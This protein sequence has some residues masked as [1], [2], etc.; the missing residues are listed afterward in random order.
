MTRFGEQEQE[1]LGYLHQWTNGAFWNRLVIL[2]RA[3]FN[4]ESL[5]E[6]SGKDKSYWFKSQ[7][8]DVDAIRNLILNVGKQTNKNGQQKWTIRRN[9]RDTPLKSTDLQG[10]K[11]VPFD[12]K[13]TIFC[14]K[15]RPGCTPADSQKCQNTKFRK[16]CHKMPIWENEAPFEDRQFDYKQN[17]NDFYHENE[18]E[19]VLFWEDIATNRKSKFFFYEQLKILTKYIKEATPIRTNRDVFKREVA[20][21]NDLYDK[22]FISKTTDIK[23]CT[24]PRTEQKLQ[25]KHTG[26]CN[27]WGVWGIETD[28]PICG[29]GSRRNKRFCY[30][31]KWQMVDDNLC[32]L[33]GRTRN[34]QVIACKNKCRWSGWVRTNCFDTCHREWFRDCLRVDRWTSKVDTNLCSR[35]LGGSHRKEDKWNNN[36]G[37]WGCKVK[38]N[39]A[40]WNG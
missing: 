37:G 21:W 26:Q 31:S 32:K 33:N 25:L 39:D 38:W 12:A 3:S 18:Y 5:I 15:I 40:I 36:C 35:V 1:I 20:E 16:S 34:T 22:K 17:D 10:L 13:Q 9:G 2:D 4:Y 28:C 7:T 24:I 29:D 6:R 8:T 23:Q 19:E 27:R 14:D 11:R 30:T